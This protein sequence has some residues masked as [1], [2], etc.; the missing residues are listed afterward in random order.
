MEKLR[1]VAIDRYTMNAMLSSNEK[2]EGPPISESR[3]P[4]ADG[5][6]KDLL[7]N[8]IDSSKALDVRSGWTECTPTSATNR[9]VAIG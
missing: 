7:V 8:L 1:N 3:E 9:S 4:E 2:R 6:L 5:R